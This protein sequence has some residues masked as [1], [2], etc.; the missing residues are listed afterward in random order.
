MSGVLGFGKIRT[1]VGVSDDLGRPP[2]RPGVGETAMR[3]GTAPDRGDQPNG[4]L[5]RLAR[6]SPPVVAMVT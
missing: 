1:A 2:G 5:S 3:Q 6:L 4:P